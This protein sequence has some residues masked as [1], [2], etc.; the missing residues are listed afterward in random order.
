[1]ADR[2]TRNA[3][4]TLNMLLERSIEVQKYIYLC[5][6]DYSKAFDK[7]RHD[8]LFAILK[9][10]NIDAKDLR[11]LRNLYWEQTA[12]IRMDSEISD[13]RAIK[14]GVRQG[15]VASPDLFN[16]Y[17][18]MILRNLNEH[19]GVKVGGNNRELTIS[20]HGQLRLRRGLSTN[21]V[22]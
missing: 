10:L 22:T 4:F 3:I 6:I 14:R 12:A 1:M 13:Y 5:F 16:L 7:V 18:E 2:G 11:I 8:D 15:C 17:S 19:Q 21:A 20:L 9:G